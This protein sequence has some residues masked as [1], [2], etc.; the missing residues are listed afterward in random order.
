MKKYPFRI[1]VFHYD[2]YNADYPLIISDNPNYKNVKSFLKTIPLEYEFS[3]IRVT[4]SALVNNEYVVF[5]RYDTYNCCCDTLQSLL[6]K[7]KPIRFNI[8]T[9][10]RDKALKKALELFQITK[11]CNPTCISIELE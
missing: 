11:H 7:E 10:S 6:G 2:F 4:V 3:D 8:F 1:E 9:T 5:K